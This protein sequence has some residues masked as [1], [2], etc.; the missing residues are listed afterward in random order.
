LAYGVVAHADGEGKWWTSVPTWATGACVS[1]S[2]VKR[3]IAKAERAGL[4]EREPYL[5]PDGYQGSSTY[6]V[7][8]ALVAE[9]IAASG[10]ETGFD[11]D[12]AAARQLVRER[13][14]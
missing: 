6:R 9:A 14:G 5:R 2:T 8:S 7:R 1:E 11:G 12:R 13:V 3:A 10:A 4:L